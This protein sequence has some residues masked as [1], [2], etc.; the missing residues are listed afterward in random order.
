MANLVE[1]AKNQIDALLAESLK[2]AAEK[3]E[4]PSGAALSG[5]VEVPKDTNNGDF[6]ANH[7]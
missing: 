5:T 1:K 4:L 7:A 2:R 6:A 3:G